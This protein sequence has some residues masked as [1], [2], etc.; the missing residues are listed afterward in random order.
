MKKIVWFFILVLVVTMIG[1]AESKNQ[2]QVEQKYGP[3]AQKEETDGK[4]IY[5]YYFEGRRQRIPYERYK[6]T[7]EFIFDRDGKLIEKR[8]YLSQPTA[9]RGN[10]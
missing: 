1:C 5:Y 8:K 2:T 4:T 7:F 6:S 9:E 3:P 10:P